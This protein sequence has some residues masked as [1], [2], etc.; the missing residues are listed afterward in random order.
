MHILNGQIAAF[1]EQHPVRFTVDCDFEKSAY[2]F[3][4]WDVAE[5]DPRWGLVV[6][7]CLHN[8]RSALDHLVYQLAILHLGRELTEQEARRAMFPVH[9]TP[10]SYRD[11]GARHV[12]DLRDVDRARIEILQPY[13]A[14]DESIWGPDKMPGPPAPVPRYLDLLSRLDNTDKHRTIQPVW[15]TPGL[16][17]LPVGASELGITGGSNSNCPLHDGAEIGRWHFD[18]VPPEPPAEM[19]VEA[20]FPLQIS[21]WEPFFGTRAQRILGNCIIAV[22]MVLDI[23]EPCLT[24]DSDPADLR[25]WDGQP[26]WL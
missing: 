26:P 16:V 2:V 12:R 19:D 8:A 1:R 18:R 11:N 21:L 15:F 9:E 13:H 6:G 17:N 5:P 23:F 14:L 24:H 4:V 25:Y 7:D 22:D 10:D 3:R 20:Y